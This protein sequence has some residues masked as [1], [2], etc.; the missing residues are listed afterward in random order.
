MD[1]QVEPSLSEL[2]GAAVKVARN[3]GVSW[4]AIGDVLGLDPQTASGRYAAFVGGG[5]WFS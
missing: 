3:A 5:D 2:L 4:D 1:S